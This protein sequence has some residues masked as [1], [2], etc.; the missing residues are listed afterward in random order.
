MYYMHFVLLL[1]IE[2][3]NDFLFCKYK[4]IVNQF[5][6]K[7]IAL[8]KMCFFKKKRTLSFKTLKNRASTSPRFKVPKEDEIYLE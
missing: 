4:K 3:N 6:A 5:C 2:Q 7:I 8:K 1:E